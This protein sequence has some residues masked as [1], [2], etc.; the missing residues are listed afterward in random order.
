MKELKEDIL[1][2]LVKREGLE[3]IISFKGSLAKSKTLSLLNDA[4]FLLHPHL[5]DGLS[6]TM[7]ESISL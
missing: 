2:Y 3:D 7:L 4:N 1:E 6:N 5:V